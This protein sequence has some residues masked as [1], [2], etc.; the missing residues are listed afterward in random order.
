MP[1]TGEEI[2]VVESYNKYANVENI[3]RTRGG[4]I[5]G[6]MKGRPEWQTHNHFLM[7][8]KNRNNLARILYK[9]NQFGKNVL[10]NVEQQKAISC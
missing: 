6:I 4:A 7:P 10:Q 8:I 1:A 3:I 9:P 2:Q 5:S